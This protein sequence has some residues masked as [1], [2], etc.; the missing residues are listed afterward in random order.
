MIKAIIFDFGS[1]I[2]KTDWDKM[3]REFI[4]KFGI[5]IRLEELKN[6]R[7]NSLYRLGSVGKAK[8]GEVIKE[9]HPNAKVTKEMI[10]SYKKL[11]MKHKII[12]HELLGLVKELKKRYLLFAFT[13]VNR[14]HYESNFEMGLY[15]D[16]KEVYT[17]FNFNMLKTQD[18]AFDKLKKELLKYSLLP[19]E[20]VFIDDYLPN[21]GQAKKVGFHTIH[22]ME[23]PNIMKLKKDLME[24]LK[25]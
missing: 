11:Y 13:D 21:I 18:G 8:I 3:S 22:Y 7:A 6:E 9:L 4:D 14:E 10:D 5:N 16:F 2:Y 17:S 20:C 25:R 23:F 1:V 15:K 24:M 19:E 12:N